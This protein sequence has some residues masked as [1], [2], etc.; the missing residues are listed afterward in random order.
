MSNKVKA[1]TIII[2]NLNIINNL[3]KILK[4]IS[5]KKIINISSISLYP[6]KDGKFNE[7]SQI[8]FLDTDIV[9]DILPANCQKQFRSALGNVLQV[10]TKQWRTGLQN[11]AGKINIH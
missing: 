2:K 7:E 3:I 9:L 5:F 6:N 10:W 11:N 1:K 8:N 4:M